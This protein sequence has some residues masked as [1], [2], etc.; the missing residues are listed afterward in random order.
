[1]KKVKIFF[2]ALLAL[3]ASVAFAQNITV[4]GTV[5]DASNNEPVAF[6]SI[7]LKGTMTGS[8]TD[9]DGHYSISV[10]SDGSL[11]FSSIGYKTIEV[12]VAGKSVLNVV[13]ESDSEF[14][15][16]TIVVAYGTATKSS[17]TGSA[18]MVKSETIAAHVATNVTSALAG[19][20]PGVQMISSSGDPA[21]NGSS[22]RIRGIGSMSASSAPLYILDGMPYSGTISDINPNDVESIS[23]LKDAAASAIYGARGANGVVLITT[24]KS[25]VQDINVKFD[26]KW[27]SNSRLIPQYDVIS[28]PGQYYETWYKMMYNSKA[29]NGSTAAEAYAYADAN[30]FNQ[31]NGGLGYQVFT[32]LEGEKLIG[33]NFRLN[34]NAKLGYDDGEYY[35]T[36]DN[37]Y[38]EAFHNSFRQEYNLSANGNKGGLTYYASAGYLNDG[39][40]ISNSGYE[41]YTARINADYQAKKWL[42]FTA[43]MG[44]SHTES[45]SPGTYGYGSSGNI[46]YVANTIGPIYPLYVRAT[47]THEIMTDQG[48]TVYDANNTNFKRPTV[49]GNA[50]RDNEVNSKNN[51]ADVLTGKWGV[52]VSPVKGLDLSA[53][54]GLF[55]DNT[56]YNALY[57]QFGSAASTDGEA[58]VSHSRTFD[59]NTQYLATYKT[60]FGGSDHHLDVLAGFEMYKNKSQ[61]LSGSNT[62]LYN[63]FVGE[64]NNADGKSDLAASSSTSDYMTE[65]ILSRV[66]YDYAGKYFVS[67]SFR[68]D[69]SSNFAKGHRWGNFGSVGLGWLISK[70]NFMSGASWVDFLKLKASYGVQGNDSIGSFRYIDQY[71]HSYN[72]ETGEYSLT[73]SRK[74]NED[75]TWESSHSFNVGVDFELFGGYLNGGIEFFDRITSDL[76]YSK[77]V[78]LSSGNPTGTIPVNVGSIDNKGVEVILDGA[79]VKTKN[80]NWNWNI[81]LS[82][83]KNTILSLD[84][85]VSEEGIKGSNY[86]YKVGGSL[87][88]SYVRKFAGVD[89]ETGKGLYYQKVMDDDNNWTGETTT[90]T[91]ITKADQFECGTTLPKVYGGFGTSFNAYG[92]DFAIQF[93]FQLGGK[94]YDGTYQSLMMTQA[95]SSA[96]NNIHKD[97]LN[98]WTPENTDTSVPRLDGDSTVGQTAVDRFFVSS[99]YLSVNNVTVGY[100]FPKKWMNKI[101]VGGLRIYV[102]GEN[103]AVVSA[104]KGVDPRYSMGIGSLTSGSGLNSGAYSAMRNISGGITLT[105]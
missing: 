71:T 60:D 65:G 99:N 53:N 77:N 26:A 73:L 6:A 56:R 12:S 62:H 104:R 1:M 37:W 74:G 105:F 48:R 41:R 15:D 63:P 7:Q 69:A 35:Y 8:T 91:D 87:Y 43:N 81:N 96:G 13:L 47:E 50:I 103:L 101:K 38:K 22:I 31:I 94:Y 46:F 23:V 83:Y 45:Q 44:Y 49:V 85:S 51:Y 64:L 28:D 61:S 92:F 34:P 55:N 54:V 36:P 72:E 79:F 16:E 98:A 19:T 57:S 68:R 67:G 80:V 17:F 97:L 86:I 42:R 70:E 102:A 4:T 59:V 100:T 88:D 10:P 58:Y 18:A 76:L 93:S 82:H 32:V 9:A 33:T 27:G 25:G 24:K 3:A 39:G 2:T 11:I 5:S 30:L 84:E 52:V 21:S 66:Q 90:T 20:T 95:S 75:L 14:I 78:P 29:Y 40:I 89:P